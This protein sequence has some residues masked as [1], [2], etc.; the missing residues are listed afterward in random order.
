MSDYEPIGATP[1][2]QDEQ[3]ELLPD[4][5][6]TRGDLNEWEQDNIDEAILWAQTTRIPALDEATIRE[7]HRRMFDRTWAWAGT[8]RRS[9]T[10]IG[11]VA[12]PDIPAE[13]RK[14]VDDGA[15]WLEHG[16]STVDETVL[17][18]HH[19]LVG[20]IHPFPNGNGRHGRLWCDLLLKQSGRPPF[21]WKNTELGSD[22][23]ARRAYIRSL[24]AADGG[25]YNPLRGLLLR[26]R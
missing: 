3:D 18:L 23:E 24:Q 10:N 25:D 8:Y 13:V 14:L 21:G 4:H 6:D 17:R 9:A 2:T 15:Y 19:R 5:L 16:E 26:G 11:N 22:G 12:C 20:H 7:L 1:L